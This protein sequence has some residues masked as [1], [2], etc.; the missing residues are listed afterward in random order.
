MATMIPGRMKVREFILILR[1][2]IR[3]V[4]KMRVVPIIAIG[5]K[6]PQKFL[7]QKIR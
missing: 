3:P 6:T 4:I 1:N 7:K 5:R 2:P